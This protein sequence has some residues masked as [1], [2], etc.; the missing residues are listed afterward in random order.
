MQ[1]CVTHLADLRTGRLIEP[2]HLKGTEMNLDR[3]SHLAGLTT[4]TSGH[5]D[6]H[7]G[8][9]RGVQDFAKWLRHDVC[10]RGEQKSPGLGL[11]KVGHTWK[12][13]CDMTN[14]QFQRSTSQVEEISCKLIAAST[15]T[16]FEAKRS[17]SH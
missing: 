15:C 8:R 5:R 11:A 17:A 9:T 12:P 3:A 2:I 10:C 7:L 16:M 4:L 6:L 14:Y 1:R 13:R